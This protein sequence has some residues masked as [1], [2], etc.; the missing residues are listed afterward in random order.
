MATYTGLISARP[1]DFQTSSLV[2]NEQC[3]LACQKG[4]SGE[5]PSTLPPMYAPVYV[6]LP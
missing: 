6:L 1:I 4:G 3:L 2:C 5:P